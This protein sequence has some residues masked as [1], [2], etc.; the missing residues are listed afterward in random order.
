[1]LVGARGPA[2]SEECG[3]KRAVSSVCALIVR[4]PI[5]PAGTIEAAVYETSKKHVRASVRTKN[6][7]VIEVKGRQV[8][9]AVREAGETGLD[10]SVQGKCDEEGLQAAVLHTSSGS[11]LARTRRSSAKGSKNHT[12]PSRPSKKQ[13]RT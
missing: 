9:L 7:A 11:L 6:L 10:G 3:I 5:D 1:M 4:L 2:F 13:D 12:R 8:R